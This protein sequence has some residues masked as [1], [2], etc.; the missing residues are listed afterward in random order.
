MLLVVG[1]IYAVIYFVIFYFLIKVFNLKT[2]GR[3]DEDEEQSIEGE[4]AADNVGNNKYEKMAYQFIQD[5]GGRENISSIE[6][7]TTRLRLDI[8][9][10]EKVNDS[11]LK[12]HGAKGVIKLNKKN[13]QI[14]V[15]TEVEFVADAMKK[16][17]RS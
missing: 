5:I 10:M 4:T 12:A 16:I 2:P 11:A 9:D 6:N 7:C 17:D 8:N 3:E 1:L 14:V 13:L 15:G